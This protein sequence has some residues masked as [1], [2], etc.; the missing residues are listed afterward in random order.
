MMSHSLVIDFTNRLREYAWQCMA[1]AFGYYTR[2]WV[3]APDFF[4]SMFDA[5]SYVWPLHS[6]ENVFNHK[7]NGT[8]F[9]GTCFTASGR[10]LWNLQKHSNFHPQ[11]VDRTITVLCCSRKYLHQQL[12]KK[13]RSRIVFNFACNISNILRLWDSNLVGGSLMTCRILCV[14]KHFF[15]YKKAFGDVSFF[16]YFSGLSA[17]L[18]SLGRLNSRRMYWFW[19]KQTITLQ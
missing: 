15:P 10:S 7:D 5:P 1:T 14:W 6:H 19:K 16:F 12:S 3:K 8:A 4:S 9:N 18:F 11:I 13:L 17:F 2:I